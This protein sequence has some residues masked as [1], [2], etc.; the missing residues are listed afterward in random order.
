MDPSPTQRFYTKQLTRPRG[1]LKHAK[2][3]AEFS[4]QGDE[5]NEGEK[6]PIRLWGPKACNLNRREQRTT[7]LPGRFATHEATKEGLARKKKSQ[8]QICCAKYSLGFAGP[9]THRRF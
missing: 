3:V 2:G 6:D 8:L 7:A 5:A 9:Q 1:Y 4:H